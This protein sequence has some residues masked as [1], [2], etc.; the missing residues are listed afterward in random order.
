MKR[1]F[2]GNGWKFPLGLK[3]GAFELVSEDED[4]KEAILIILNTAPGERVMR[5]E[6]GCGIQNYLFSVINSS[7]LSMIENEVT[8]ALTL[9]E[10]R[11]E[12][13]RVKAEVESSEE[14]K[15]VVKIDYSVR[16][17]NSRYNIV[18]PFYLTERG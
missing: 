9:Y 6:F 8:R 2:L 12:L 14:G 15:L 18:Y 11:I 1:E 5:P 16:S 13:E 10:P 3:E 17:S 4:I 7:N